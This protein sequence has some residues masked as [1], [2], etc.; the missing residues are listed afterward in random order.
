MVT[1]KWLSRKAAD[2]VSSTCE[3]C[4]ISTIRF[5]GS[6]EYHLIHHRQGKAVQQKEDKDRRTSHKLFKV[7]ISFHAWV[8]KQCWGNSHITAATWLKCMYTFINE[9]VRCQQAQCYLSSFSHPQN[10]CHADGERYG[11]SNPQSS[12]S[13]TSEV[14]QAESEVSQAE[15][16]TGSRDSLSSTAGIAPWDLE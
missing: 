5:S 15:F 9:Q 12:N 11:R 6:D 4:W 2:F 7:F 3:N 10:C 13:L 16:Y 1:V 8:S 14:R